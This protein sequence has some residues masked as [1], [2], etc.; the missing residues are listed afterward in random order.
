[1]TSDFAFPDRFWSSWRM[2]AVSESSRTVI[3]SDMF[4]FV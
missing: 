4:L 2:R 1:M 3:L